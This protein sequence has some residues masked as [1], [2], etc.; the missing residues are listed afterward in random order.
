M[1][2]FHS[3]N[4]SVLIW[5]LLHE[6]LSFQLHKCSLLVLS[7]SYS[8]ILPLDS[9]D[10]ISITSNATPL[11]SK[12]EERKKQKDDD[13]GHV[14]TVVPQSGSESTHPLQRFGLDLDD[15]Q[16][17]DS[18]NSLRKVLIL[19]LIHLNCELIRIWNLNFDVSPLISFILHDLL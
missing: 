17:L 5:W 10:S 12:D 18:L 4:L 14:I 19:L 1:I 7:C 3:F 2:N 11:L 9:T 8:M 6:T 15:T 13:P 16:L